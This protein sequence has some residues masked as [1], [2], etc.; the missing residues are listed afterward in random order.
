MQ[1][2][3][4]HFPQNRSY[5]K[6]PSLEAYPLIYTFLIT[7]IISFYVEQNHEALHLQN[8]PLSVFDCIGAIVVCVW[9]L[10]DTFL[11][12]LNDRAPQY[13]LGIPP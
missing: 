1:R 11:G 5:K 13:S 12:T 10:G 8:V 4:T 7:P 9:I 2:L 3:Y 6:I